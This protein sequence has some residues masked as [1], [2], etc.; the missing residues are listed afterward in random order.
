MTCFHY[1]VGY[2]FHYYYF[3]GFDDAIMIMLLV[4]NDGDYYYDYD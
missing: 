2:G 1:F 4:K 3:V